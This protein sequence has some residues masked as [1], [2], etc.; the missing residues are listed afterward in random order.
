MST[1]FATRSRPK[2]WRALRGVLVALSP[3]LLVVTLVV[4]AVETTPRIA[5]PGPPDARAASHTRDVA[6]SLRYFVAS[7]GAA[8]AWS[9]GE[10]ELNAV[11]A[12]AQRLVPGSYGLARVGDD[13]LV[14][15]LSVGAPV[16]P[17]GLWANL[18]LALAPS[19]DGLEIASA[20]IGRLP[21]PPAL[22]RAG[23]RLALDRKLGDR[24]GTEALASI[25]GLRLAP[26]EMTLVFDFDAVGRVAF[27]ERLRARALEVAG[28]TARDGVYVQLWH[29]D[30]A[31]RRDRLPRD[32]SMIPYVRKAINVAGRQPGADREEL[33]AALYALALYCGDPD[34]GDQIGVTLRESL[35]GD[36]NGC[37]GTTLGGRDDFKRHFVISAGLQ[38]ATAS[39]AAFGMGELKELLD[40]NEG[41]SGFS[42][43]DMVADAAGVRFAR[44]FLEVPRDQWPALLNR[45]R[46]EDDLLPAFD[47]LPEHLSE[48]EFRARY[49]DVDS[50]AY[51]A[52]V[53]EIEARVDAL[54]LYAGE[55]AG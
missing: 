5:N 21:V 26:P 1:A 40:S 54:P 14:I 38:A 3:L 27:F 23:L 9:A 29:F 34:F 42:F 49:G 46:S 28:A 44:A 2:R 24:L 6:D 12:A 45:I 31:V 11:L 20:R 18:H 22:A 36:A 7:Q 37:D 8:G 10:E 35:Q 55:P 33:R 25:A 48:S 41:G 19:E 47:D 50:A 43:K 4:L 39:S 30:R 13:A 17:A 16:M 53:R 52:M 32:G 51:A 15:D